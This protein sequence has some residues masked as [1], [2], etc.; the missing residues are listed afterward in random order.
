MKK[1]LSGFGTDKNFNSDGSIT[2]QG[3]V[4]EIINCFKTS[5]TQE[6][7][8]TETIFASQFIILL[9]PKN[10]EKRVNTF[11]YV[12]SESVQLFYKRLRKESR[13]R[14]VSPPLIPMWSFNFAPAEIFDSEEIRSIKV[15][16]TTAKIDFNNLKG[17]TKINITIKRT[18]NEVYQQLDIEQNTFKGIKFKNEGKFEV[19]YDP[20]LA[21]DKRRLWSI[22]KC[23]EKFLKK[24][25]ENAKTSPNSTS[26]GSEKA[27]STSGKAIAQIKWTLA[28]KSKQGLYTMKVHEIVIARDTTENKANPNYL[29]ID[30]VYVSRIHARI[31]YLKTTSQF[32]IASFSRYP[33]L[34]GGEPIPQSNPD[35]PSWTDLP[36]NAEITL[37][38]QIIMI[39]TGSR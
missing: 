26:R 19:P 32:Q 31:R 15:F 18:D 5:I 25:K 37:N 30:S 11:I 4:N 38:D 17:N 27:Q 7:L 29:L 14:N 39:F 23:I 22:F 10:Y 2:N 12:V 24:D 13:K 9:T 16:G 33:T 3:V 6:S 8:K 28:D 35:T 20:N 1:G 21:E 36:I 34:I